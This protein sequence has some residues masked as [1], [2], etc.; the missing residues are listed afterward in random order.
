MGQNYNIKNIRALFKQGFT[1]EE[2]LELSYDEPAFRPVYEQLSTSAGKG[3]IVQRLIEYA[4]RQSLLDHLLNCARERNLA[5]YEQYQPYTASPSNFPLPPAIKQAV[6]ALDSPNPSER[7]S[8]IESL[9]QMNHPVVPEALAGAV[10]HTIRDVRIQAALVLAQFKDSRALPG[11][12]EALIDDNKNHLI[13]EPLANVLK[14]IEIFRK[15]LQE[16]EIVANHHRFLAEQSI[17]YAAVIALEEIPDIGIATDL[18]KTL[19]DDDWHVRR[20]SAR[21]LGKIGAIVAVPSLLQA[22]DDKSELVRETVVMSL[23]K[24]GNDATIQGLIAFLLDERYVIPSDL[25]R[26]LI[27]SGFKLRRQIAGTLERIGTPE[28]LVAANEWRSREKQIERKTIFR[29]SWGEGF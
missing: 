15:I 9:A 13:G 1:P 24:I 10:Q 22:L 5:S 8:A 14:D 21:V 3:Q 23:E 26:A 2:L 25:K 18:L 16:F 4:E 7:L 29:S 27:D 20:I 6:A 17:R 11:L 12:H 19:K 28:A